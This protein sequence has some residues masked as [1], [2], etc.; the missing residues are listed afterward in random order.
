MH[1]IIGLITAF[2]VVPIV[3]NVR[4]FG[5]RCDFDFQCMEWLRIK[6]HMKY[7]NVICGLTNLLHLSSLSNKMIKPM[8]LPCGF[9]ERSVIET[10]AQVSGAEL[11]VRIEK[12]LTTKD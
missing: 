12:A 6:K 2:I 7:T 11:K 8:V 4:Q 3:F 1:F 9:D 5:V 10:H